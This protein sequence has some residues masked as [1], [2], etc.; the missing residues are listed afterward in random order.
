MCAYTIMLYKYYRTLELYYQWKGEG[1]IY[2]IILSFFIDL[3]VHY[4]FGNR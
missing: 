4:I 1:V 3:P 2:S